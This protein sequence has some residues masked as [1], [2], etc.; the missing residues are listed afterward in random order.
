V[1]ILKS[2]GVVD[3]I[4]LLHQPD[5]GGDHEPI[6]AGITAAAIIYRLGIVAVLGERLK[7]D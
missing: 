6:I 4:F 2:S 7:A 3:F 5:A 1:L